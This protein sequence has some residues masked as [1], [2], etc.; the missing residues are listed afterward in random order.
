MTTASTELPVYVVT[1][2]A[3]GIGRATVA[4]LAQ[5][6]HVWALDLDPG[7]TT[8]WE[9]NA[10]VH[11]LIADVR[12][13]NGLTRAIQTVCD[14]SGGIDGLVACAG[15]CR[16]ASLA[17]TTREIWDSTIETN[18]RGTFYAIREVHPHLVR[19]GR[20]SI[21][22]VASELALVGQPN[23]SA[24]AASKAGMVG[25]IRALA[26]ELAPEVRCNIVAP[27]PIATE[28]LEG[29]QRSR[30]EPLEEA[31][32]G[33]PLG[34]VGRPEEV[35]ELIRFLLDPGSSF[36]TGAVYMVDGGLTAQ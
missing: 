34:R 21:V 30:G 24:Y 35:A 2:A 10:R 32:T 27:G 28:M 6:A 31:A 11:G 13:E 12:D 19:S 23:L 26:L 29:F 25:L 22:A 9:S 7:V 18:L 15:I 33:I 17:A 16:P 5:T 20:G 36:I 8:V 3:S 14:Q 4:L 1:G